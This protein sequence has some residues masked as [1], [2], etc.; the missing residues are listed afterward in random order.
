[1]AWLQTSLHL[2]LSWIRLFQFEISTFI[3]FR[4]RLTIWPL[5]SSYHISTQNLFC[6]SYILAITF[7]Y[8]DLGI[9]IPRWFSSSILPPSLFPPHI[10]PFFPI[11]PIFPSRWHLFSSFHIHMLLEL[12]YCCIC[13]SF[14]FA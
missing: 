6:S 13:S 3:N 1:M 7:Y 2:F 14:S 11:S 8:L 5:F 10:P 9:L 12:N 4:R